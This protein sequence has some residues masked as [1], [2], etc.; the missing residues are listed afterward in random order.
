M[1]LVVSKKAVGMPPG[2]ALTKKGVFQW[3]CKFKNAILPSDIPHI[4][5][6]GLN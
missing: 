3:A 5:Y 6:P 1:L 2:Q 4:P